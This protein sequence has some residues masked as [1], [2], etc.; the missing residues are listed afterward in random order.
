MDRERVRHF[1]SAVVARA[2]GT[3]VGRRQQRATL[4]GISVGMVAGCHAIDK[5]D[6][7]VVSILYCSARI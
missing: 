5:L 7:A 6:S 3:G 1:G 4:N 2:G